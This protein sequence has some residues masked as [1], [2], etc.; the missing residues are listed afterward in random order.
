VTEATRE[1]P[2][3]RAVPAWAVLGGLVLASAA[4]RFWAGTRI[5]G[6]WIMPDEAV[7]ASLG[8]SVY[9]SLDLSIFGGSTGLYSLVYPLVEGLPLA[10]G[11]L[12]RG[13]ELLKAWQAVVMSLTAVPV[14]LWGRRLTSPRWALAAAALTLLMPG[15]LYSGLVMTEVAF[16][17]VAV[18]AAW[19][20]ARALEQ[21]TGGRQAL[22]VGAIAL[23]GATRLQALVLLPVFLTALALDAG[24]RRSL[25]T[26]RRFT[27]TLAG[28]A[29]LLLGW[30]VYRLHAGGPWQQ[31]LGSYQAATSAPWDPEKIAR[32]VLYHLAD[33]MLL[34]GAV[35]LCAL[36]LLAV[37]ALRG[38]EESPAVR[39]HVAVALSLVAWFVVEVGVFAS[40]HVDRLAERDLLALA[41][42]LFLSLGIWLERGGPRPRVVTAVVAVVAFLVV[43]AVPWRRFSQAE[44]LPDAFSIAPLFKLIE[45]S[46]DFDPAPLVL[47][48]AAVLLAGFVLLPRRALVVLPVAVGALLCT[49]S[50]FASRE[51]AERAAYDDQYLLGGR[52]DWIER[53]VDAPVG[54]LYTGELYWNGVYQQLFWN[55]NITHVYYLYPTAVPG[56]IPQDAITIGGDGLLSRSGG[57]FISEHYIAAPATTKFIGTPIAKLDQYGIQQAGLILWRLDEDARLSYTVSGVRPDG[58]LHEPGRMIANECAGGFFRITL[59]AKAS[60]RVDILVNGTPY[61]TVRFKTDSD[62]YAEDIPAVPQRQFRTCTLEVRPD[63]LL[64]STHFEFLRP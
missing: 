58:D 34:V 45:R 16:L 61:R 5:P 1:L 21:P 12:D 55:R 32:F 50:I 51:V 11:D 22:L 27:P 19:A 43:S 36:V 24:F 56:P 23:A 20:M 25:G 13:Y 9:R 41:P 54:L 52:R 39:A 2:V 7:Y 10:Y 63:S 62:T 47:I 17:P 53:A 30:A 38:R 57:R 49:G 29:V 46:P 15:L 33:T 37:H 60:R 42:V 3:V 44:A 4:L 14:Y 48:V 64:G 31:V 6:L 28:L 59:I 35:P 40:A 18:L 8:Q 26:V